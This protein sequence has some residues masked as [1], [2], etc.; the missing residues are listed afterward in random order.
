MRPKRKFRKVN[1]TRLGFFSCKLSRKWLWIASNIEAR[2]QSLQCSHQLD[3][4][5]KTQLSDKSWEVWE[6][7]RSLA[8][9]GGR[10]LTRM[11]AA[12]PGWG[13]SGWASAPGGRR[14]SLAPGSGSGEPAAFP[15]RRGLRWWLHGRSISAPPGRRELS[16]AGREESRT[17]TSISSQTSHVEINGVVSE[18]AQSILRWRSCDTNIKN[19]GWQTKESE[20]GNSNLL[21]LFCS[22]L[23]VRHQRPSLWEVTPQDGWNDLFFVGLIIP[24]RQLCHL[25]LRWK[26]N[27][28]L[29][30]SSV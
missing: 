5:V 1:K 9:D 19:E 13:G 25:S 11:T 4:S 27:K 24:V 26:L 20:M 30:H 15:G 17:R 21:L 10:T 18:L 8:V 2:G 29:W 23:L 28:I 16:G 7:R 22:V 14:T 6:T 12:V 3:L